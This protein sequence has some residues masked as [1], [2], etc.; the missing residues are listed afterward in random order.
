V[1]HDH[2]S[3]YGHE[4]HDELRHP[5]LRYAAKQ[6]DNSTYDGRNHYPS[7]V[8]AWSCGARKQEKREC[9]KRW[10]KQAAQTLLLPDEGIDS[11]KDEDNRHEG[12]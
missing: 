8:G 11:R 10:N 12:R 6:P 4:Y 2:R 1:H 7:Q 5:C 3:G 9:R